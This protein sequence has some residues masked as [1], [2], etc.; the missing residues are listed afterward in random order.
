MAGKADTDKTFERIGNLVCKGNLSMTIILVILIGLFLL[1]FWDL[2]VGVSNDAVNFTNSAVGSRITSRKVIVTVAGFG[3]IAGTLFSSGMMEVARK[4]IFNPGM[5]I[6]PEVL[7]I[8]LA[9]MFADVLLLDVYNTY[10]LPTST[11]VSLIFELLGAAVGLSFIKVIRSGGDFSGVTAYINSDKVMAIILGIF[12]SVLVAFTCGVIFQFITRLFFTFRYKRYLKRF[13]AGA[14]SL[15]MMVLIYFIFIKGLTGSGIFS[16]SFIQWVLTF[17]WIITIVIFLILFFIFHLLLVFTRMNIAKFI[18]LAGTFALALAFSANDL[19]NFVGVAMAGLEAF[20]IA[21]QGVQPMLMSMEGLAEP[22]HSDIYLLVI[23]GMIMAVTLW[24][25]KKARRVTKTEVNLARQ[26][27]LNEKF[28]TTIVS[29]SVVQ[30]T[31]GSFAFLGKAVPRTARDFIAGR[32]NPSEF[33][34]EKSKGGKM[35]AFD[36]IRAA[37]NLVVA[38]A[39]IALGTSYK[40]PLSTTYV[41]FM[42]AMGTS[43]ADKAWGHESAVHRVNGVLTVIGGWLFTALIAFVLAFIFVNIIQLTQLVGIILLAVLTVYV[44]VKTNGIFRSR[45][46]NDE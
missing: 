39:L 4:G 29:R 36:P 23:A 32:I 9:V 5:F 28:G 44:F 19:V 33:R 42:V 7:Y 11:T 16:D 10:G 31:V 26:L 3:I 17:R 2:I 27:A 1:A 30:M 24:V 37:V 12:L 34:P 45:E 15:S 6:L 13:G 20:R 41:T 38:A 35:A 25:S 40:L 21:S 22:V 8:F 14:A 43:L 46:T 18:I